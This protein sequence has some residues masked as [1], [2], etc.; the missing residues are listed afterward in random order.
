MMVSKQKKITV[1]VSGHGSGLKLV[2]YRFEGLMTR[3]HKGFTLI[4]LIIVMVIVSILA[5]MTTDI[6]T[7]PVKSYIDLER[8]TTLVDTAEITLR[9]MQRDIRR[10]FT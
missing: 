7:L 2:G 1:N 8:R 3:Q 10:A 5:T 9:R 6:I 4:E